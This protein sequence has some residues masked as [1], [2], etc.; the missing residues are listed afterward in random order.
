MFTTMGAYD[1][2]VLG[3]QGDSRELKGA[4]SVYV[5]WKYDGSV[6]AQ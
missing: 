4:R 6:V 3:R 2:A 5:S 1:T